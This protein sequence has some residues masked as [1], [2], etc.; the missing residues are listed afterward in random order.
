MLEV[1]QY[2]CPLNVRGRAID[3]WLVQLLSILPQC[4]DVVTENN[5]FVTPS[6]LVE[7]NQKLAGH[8]LVGVH[9]VQQLPAVTSQGG[10][11]DR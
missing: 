2:P 8:E 7:V 5:D 10:R 4:P 9:A 11:V 6:A 3:E 1:V